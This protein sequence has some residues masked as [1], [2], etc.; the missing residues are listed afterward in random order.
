[1]LACRWSQTLCVCPQRDGF[2]GLWS[3]QWEISVNH[4]DKEFETLEEELDWASP[5]GLNLSLT[6]YDSQLVVQHYR[7]PCT[8]LLDHF[9]V[10]H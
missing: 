2:S 6:V 4:R 9:L 3:S 7:F 8:L 1:M 10:M 5:S